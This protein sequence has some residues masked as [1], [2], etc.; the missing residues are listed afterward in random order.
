MNYI[1]L[2]MHS[3]FS[4]D[5][6]YTP[7]DLLN[8]AR[9]QNIQ[10][11]SITDHNSV[12]AYQ[13]IIHVQDITLIP[14]IEIDCSF[15]GKDFHLLG[16]VIDVHDPIYEK[17][18]QD[19]MKQEQECSQKRLSLIKENLHLE[20]DEEQLKEI[21]PFGIYVRETI[22]EIAMEDE[23][24]K[25]NPYLQPYFPQGK[26]SDNPYVNFYWDYCSQ[27]KIAYT[28]INYISME[29]AISLY[30]K[31]GGIAVLAHP[32]NNVKEDIQLMNDIRNLGIDGIEVYSS[33]HKHEQIKFYHDICQKYN[34]IETA[35]SDFHGK[36]K[37]SVSMGL[38]H[39][40]EEQEETLI[41]TILSLKK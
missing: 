23:R 12:K 38:C 16:Y 19:I 15:Q 8:M 4:I 39:M 14:G 26:R 34:L 33:Y 1:D 3:N 28:K 40:P 2:H 7:Q 30:H 20:I 6:E 9:Q 13:S 22:C 10:I 31:Q 25:D 29:E 32:G 5:G 21:S 36:T 11:V 35:G 41:K 17:I 18:E 24:N 27:G 37:P